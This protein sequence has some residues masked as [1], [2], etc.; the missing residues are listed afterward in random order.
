MNVGVYSVHEMGIG[1]R[2]IYVSVIPRDGRTFKDISRNETVCRE[3]KVLFLVITRCSCMFVF[4]FLITW[5]F[6]WEEKMEFF[7]VNGNTMK[8]TVGGGMLPCLV[9]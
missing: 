2:N 9:C 7:F 5:E 3:K 1:M 4:F 8:N 6:M